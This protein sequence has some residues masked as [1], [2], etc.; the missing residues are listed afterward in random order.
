NSPRGVVFATPGSGFMVSANAGQAV[1]IQFGF[2]DQLQTFSPQR[3]FTALGSPTTD[4][5]FFVAG[6][7]TP[8]TTSAF[9]VVFSDVDVAGQT[10]IDFFD[11]LG[12]LILGRDV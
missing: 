10:H 2:A 8:G 3:L 5:S 6:T 1:P 4:V 9:G 12:H 7:S 11:T